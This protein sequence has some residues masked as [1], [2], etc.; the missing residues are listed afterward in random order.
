MTIFKLMQ[1]INKEVPDVL[2]GGGKGTVKP[3]ATPPPLAPEPEKMETLQ[4]AP[5]DVAKR[6]AR[7]QGA[8]SLQIPLGTIGGTDVLN[9]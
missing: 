2:R 1:V 8:K 6:E 3:I 5:E 7:T 4:T 9:K